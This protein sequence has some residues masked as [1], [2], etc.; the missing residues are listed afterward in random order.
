MK[1]QTLT[2]CGVDCAADCRSYLT[3]CAGCR[4]LRGVVPWLQYLALE[5]CPVYDCVT[6]EKG[7]TSCAGCGGFPCDK[8]AG[9]KNPAV[10][11]EEY[12]AMLQTQW[13][14]LQAEE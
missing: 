4:E 12:Q 3:A 10:S 5:G 9:I 2:P 14:R 13:R 8:F 7:Q 1:Q 11:E 6:V